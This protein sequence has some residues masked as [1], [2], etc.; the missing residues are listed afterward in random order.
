[1]NRPWG[2]AAHGAAAALAAVAA[3]AA[4]AMCLIAPAAYAQQSVGGGSASETEAKGPGKVEFPHVD[5]QVGEVD[6]QGRV[7]WQKAAD[8]SVGVDIPYRATGTLP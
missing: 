1:M 3:A 7:T 2:G 5:K 6:A 4:L 8:A